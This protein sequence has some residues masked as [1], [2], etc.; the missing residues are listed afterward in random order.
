MHK[1]QVHTWDLKIHET[2][3]SIPA[4]DTCHSSSLSVGATLKDELV[5]KIYAT[6][7]GFLF[8]LN[9][10]VPNFIVEV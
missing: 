10:K 5:Q 4:E 9:L 6:E 7:R 1:L 2:A 3:N 8:D